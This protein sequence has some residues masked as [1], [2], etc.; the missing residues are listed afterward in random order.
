MQLFINMRFLKQTAVNLDKSER[1]RSVRMYVA[2]YYVEN[3]CV[4]GLHKSLELGECHCNAHITLVSIDNAAVFPAFQFIRIVKY[5]L[6]IIWQS[7]IVIYDV[8]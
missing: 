3:V 5:L 1:L 2:A 8:K 4:V 6:S 7:N